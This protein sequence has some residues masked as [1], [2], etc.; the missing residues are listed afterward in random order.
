MVFQPVDYLIKK[1]HQPEHFFFLQSAISEMFKHTGRHFSCLFLHGFPFFGQRNDALS[2]INDAFCTD[3][4][5]H[6]LHALNERRHRV[7]LQKQLL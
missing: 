5:S 2:R 7:G 3:D 4:Q 1:W 6:F